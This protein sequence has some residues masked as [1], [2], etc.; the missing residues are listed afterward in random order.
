MARNGEAVALDEMQES[1]E[2]NAQQRGQALRPRGE[3]PEG[4]LEDGFLD[5]VQGA[6]SPRVP[7]E[8]I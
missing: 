7:H 1:V 2:R 3:R 6:A 5:F 8:R 4:A